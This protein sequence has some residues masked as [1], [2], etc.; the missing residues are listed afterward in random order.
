SLPR[1]LAAHRLSQPRADPRRPDL[2]L[3]RALRLATRARAGARPRV[4]TAR[5]AGS[6]RCD[7]GLQQEELAQVE[8]RDER[9]SL[10]RRAPEHDVEP[11]NAPR[12]QPRREGE[13]VVPYDEQRGG[14]QP[15]LE[16]EDRGAPVEK[17]LHRPTLQR[18][19][20]VS[21]EP[22]GGREVELAT[23]P[24]LDLVE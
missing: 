8:V 19:L 18:E 11:A 16:D 5:D 20:V 10:A 1:Q 17:G 14:M 3:P 21:S 24:G 15:P 22:E 9:V 7:R 13:P 2:D 4:P 23:E 6:G 12:T